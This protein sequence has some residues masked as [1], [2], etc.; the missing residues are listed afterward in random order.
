MLIS[1]LPGDRRLTRPGL[2]AAVPPIAGWALTGLAR[3][4]SAADV[5][6]L[7][8]SCDRRRPAGRRDFAILTILARLGLRAAEVA[9]LRLADIGW[10]AGE[11]AVHGKAGLHDRLP[12]TQDVGEAAWPRSQT[13]CRRMRLQGGWARSATGGSIRPAF[14]SAW[15]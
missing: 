8:G 6:R 2:L 10:R 3:A 1:A 11:L 15:T 13:P 5:S 7:L 12:L 14:A 9:A 4:I